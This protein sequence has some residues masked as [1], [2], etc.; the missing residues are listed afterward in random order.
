MPTDTPKDYADRSLDTYAERIVR[1][2]G[3]LDGHM[4]KVASDRESDRKIT[5]QR[6]DS[7][8]QELER[9][10]DNLVTLSENQRAADLLEMRN[11]NKESRRALKLQ[12]GEYQRRLDALNGE[13]KRIAKIQEQSVS[14]ELFDE[15][16][17]GT[18]NSLDS[19][20]A[21]WSADHAALA[22][23][24]AVLEKRIERDTGKAVGRGELI[25]ILFAVVAALG[26]VVFIA[27]IYTSK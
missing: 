16:Q 5:D 2:E 6:A 27:N 14:R 25:A 20:K 10:A 3:R 19:A 18:G 9:R 4:E 21:I 11:A 23:K 22:E 26:T 12:A 17:K 7:L 13:A 8:A 15:A 24:V 1:N